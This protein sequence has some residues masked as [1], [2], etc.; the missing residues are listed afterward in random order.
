[1]EIGV[2]VRQLRDSLGLTQAEIAKATSLSD[3]Q[4][5]KL[6]RNKH[7]PSLQ[8]LRALAAVLRIKDWEELMGPVDGVRKTFADLER[9][10]F[11]AAA[12]AHQTPIGSPERDLARRKMRAYAEAS[13]APLEDQPA[14]Q[15]PAAVASEKKSKRRRKRPGPK[16][17]VVSR[18]R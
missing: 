2:R 11:D 13:G 9:E 17:S 8:T 16:T 1:M 12:A 14:L 3:G 10:A 5:S 6:E 18:K 7:D 15:K 4:V